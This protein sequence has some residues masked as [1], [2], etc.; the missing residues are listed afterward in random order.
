MEETIQNLEKSVAHVKSLNDFFSNPSNY[1]LPNEQLD[2][3]IYQ[4]NLEGVINSFASINL[5][6]ELYNPKSRQM[7]LADLYE[8][9]LL[10]RGF[11][12]IGTKRQHVFKKEN[13]VNGVLHLVNLLMNYESLTVNTNRRNRFLDFLSSNV[14]GLNKEDGFQE[15]RRYVGNVGTPKSTAGKKIGRYFDKL[16]PKTAGGLWHELL[17]YIFILRHDLGYIIPLL[18][19]QKIYSKSDHLVPPD[20][21]L[22]A[23]DKSIFGIEVGR[24]KE[25][26]SG[27][28][29]LKTNIPVVSLDTINSR[30]S[31]RCP[32][33]LQWIN[34]CPYVIKKFS[35]FNEEVS[36]K[37]EIKC[38]EECDV[39]SKLEILNGVCPFSKY[40]RKKA[41][42]LLH[43]H[44]DYSNTYHYHYSCVLDKV[45]KKKKQEIIKAKDIM[46]IKTHMPYYSGLEELEKYNNL[47]KGNENTEEAFY[48]EL[49][50]LDETQ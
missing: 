7:I 34:F 32:I 6:D 12:A 21:L 41:Q 30:N 25:T 1:N 44:H 2:F 49:E 10:G 19:H 8:Y 4:H 11:Y 3:D 38:Y 48:D 16:L 45:G 37:C 40:A 36:G 9:I 35:N 28:F 29:S 22:L 46:A 43:T 26:Q 20:F 5:D 50:K 27:N 31:D 13:F 39:Y 18:L 14:E 23:K 33:C 47:Q 15:L 42:T 24:G 17:V